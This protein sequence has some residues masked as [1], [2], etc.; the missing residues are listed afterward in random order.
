MRIM[1]VLATSFI[2]ISCS[3]PNERSTFNP[4]SGKHSSAWLPA[5]HATS[6]AQSLADC[7]QCHGAALDGGIAQVSCSSCHMGGATS[8][9]P[10]DWSPIFSA[11]GPYV[12]TSGT[13]ACANQYCHGTSLTGVENSGPSCDRY[14]GSG[15]CHSIPYDPASL[16]CDACHRIPPQGT[17][18]PNVAGSHAAHTAITGTSQATCAVCHY[19]SDGV[20][21]TGAHYDNVID[22]AI[23]SLYNAKTG[24]AAPNGANNTCTTVSC[25]G[26]QETPNW[27]TGT[28]DVNTQCTSCHSYGTAQYNN[29][30]SGQHDKHVNSEHIGCTECHDTGLL[31]VNHFGALNTAAM[32][33]PASQTIKSSIG[34]NGTSCARPCHDSENWF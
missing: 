33:G 32:E 7:S 26:G 4:E 9:H 13:A 17:D 8:V 31:A 3:S 1:L 29:F 11:H 25:H 15:G 19:G 6:A 21:A 27:L 12:N 18:Y 16:V 20:T 24:A 23:D 30:N 2:C 34:Y 10:A 22:V 5:A 14:S 28:I